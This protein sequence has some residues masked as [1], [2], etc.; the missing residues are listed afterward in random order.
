[1][2]NAGPAATQPPTSGVPAGP[3]NAGYPPVAAQAGTGRRLAPFRNP[4]GLPRTMPIPLSP[5]PGQDDLAAVLDRLEQEHFSGHLDWAGD[6]AAGRLVLLQGLVIEAHWSEGTGAGAWDQEPAMQRFLTITPGGQLTGYP[7]DP[8][9]VWSYSAIMAGHDRPQDRNLSNVQW[10]VLL[11]RAIARRLTGVVQVTAGNQQAYLFLFQG[12]TLGEY[13]P[14]PP[15][16]EEAPGAG[17]ALCGRPG[18][19]VDVY[20][21]REP[22]ELETLNH[23]LW[24]VERV[25][26]ALGKEALAVLG[27]RGQQVVKLLN[28][29]G[30][31]PQALRAAC[32]RARQVTR[33]FIGAEEYEQL[34]RRWDALLARLR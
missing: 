21:A 24:P 2:R 1:M 28:G 25:A 29:A 18:S 11:E 7:L 31:D 20:T 3:R 5:G 16:L 30:G 26:A 9:F 14:A 4:V 17:G 10:P 32:A 13:R 34:G 22:G 19:R 8:S 15:W 6:E 27:P 33:I 12:R 23:V